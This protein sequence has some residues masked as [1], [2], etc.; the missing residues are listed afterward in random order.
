M[1]WSVNPSADK[2]RRQFSK[3][4]R[5]H[6]I[7]CFQ[8]HNKKHSE[9]TLSCPRN[10]SSQADNIAEPQ[11][12]TL[13]TVPRL[14]WWPDRDTAGAKDSGERAETLLFLDCEGIKTQGFLCW[15]LLLG[16]TS[17]VT[18][19]WVNWFAE[20]DISKGNLWSN[21]YK[22][23]ADQSQEFCLEYPTW[24]WIIT[25]QTR[26]LTVVSTQSKAIVRKKWDDSDWPDTPPCTSPEL[27][28]WACHWCWR[29]TET[30]WDWFS[31]KVRNPSC[32]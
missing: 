9:W 27:S 30:I 29:G 8:S 6:G 32:Y 1:F 23:K 21:W 31:H 18:A 10:V 16:G 22:C 15:W 2:S 14:L 20:W 7:Q 5:H 13:K 26:R 19:P 24:I 12:N 28:A 4:V 11:M 3:M 17:Y 25:H